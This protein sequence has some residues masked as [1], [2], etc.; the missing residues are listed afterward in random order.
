MI[1]YRKGSP[2]FPKR[3]HGQPR[4]RRCV[5]CAAPARW[6][7]EHGVPA[8]SVKRDGRRVPFVET[9]RTFYCDAH[10]AGAR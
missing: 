3:P 1:R 4:P 7:I 9:V 10:I 6:A 5:T 8:V 2:T